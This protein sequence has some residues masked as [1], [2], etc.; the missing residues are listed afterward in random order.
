MEVV[1]GP[2]GEGCEVVDEPQPQRVTDASSTGRTE[3]RRFRLCI[4]QAHRFL[5]T[6]D[7]PRINLPPELGLG[8]LD[9]LNRAGASMSDPG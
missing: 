5:L 4:C 8:F 3:D 1:D 2:E 6:A 7:G 9:S